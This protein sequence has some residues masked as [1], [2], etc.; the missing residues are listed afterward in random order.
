MRATE[1]IAILRD[2]TFLAAGTFVFVKDALG[3]ARW[4]PMVLGML[5]AL[6]PTFVSA[7]WSGRTQAS[8]SL[9]SSVPSSPSGS[10]PSPLPSGDQ[11]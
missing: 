8:T 9:E 5:F 11:P 1:A 4:V 6:G 7:Y 10:S 2:V 3:E